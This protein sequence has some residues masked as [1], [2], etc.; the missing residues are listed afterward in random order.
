VYHP[1]KREEGDAVVRSFVK[2]GPA[3]LKGYLILD[4]LDNSD[5]A[6]YVTLWSSE[7]AMKEHFGS[8]RGDLDEAVDGLICGAT[9]YIF[10]KVRDVSLS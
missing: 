7:E 5:K 3:G 9:E 2:E 4:D 6:A 1:G 10:T 8:I